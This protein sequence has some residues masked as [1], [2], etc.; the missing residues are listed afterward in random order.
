MDARKNIVLS[1]FD[2]PHLAKW[3]RK[4]LLLALDHFVNQCGEQSFVVPGDAISSACDAPPH[5]G[6]SVQW[7]NMKFDPVDDVE[8]RT[9][10][11]NTDLDHDPNWSIAYQFI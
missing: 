1:S 3:K 5:L 11:N 9:L 7:E 6:L 2:A 4:K 8:Q 10:L